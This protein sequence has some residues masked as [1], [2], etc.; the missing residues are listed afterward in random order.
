MKKNLSSLLKKLEESQAYNDDEN[1]SSLNDALSR[2]LRKGGYDTTN[3][4]CTGT[5]QSCDNSSCV[6]SK[7]HVCRNAS[8]LD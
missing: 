1:I 2:V 6:G 5:N 8:C 4:T 3:G 7:N